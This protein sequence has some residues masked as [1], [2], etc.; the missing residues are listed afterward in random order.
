MNRFRSAAVSKT[1]R[2]GLEPLKMLRLVPCHPA[3]IR[4]PVQELS[5]RLWL[6]SERRLAAGL[7]RTSVVLC[8]ELKNV[9]VHSNRTPKAGRRPA[10]RR[11]AISGFSGD[12][13]V[14]RF[15]IWPLHWMLG[16]EC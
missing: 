4:A 5:D 2:S 13:G 14:L 16:V 11:Q 15:P 8:S 9:H 6:L 12:R 10:L 7:R 3:P 1:S